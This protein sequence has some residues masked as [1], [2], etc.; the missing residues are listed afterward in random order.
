MTRGYLVYHCLYMVNITYSMRSN[1]L[2]LAWR[3]TK[4]RSAKALIL[5][6]DRYLMKQLAQRIP[7]AHRPLKVDHNLA[8]NP[9]FV[10]IVVNIYGYG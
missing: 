4:H 10:H 9:R 8:R 7:K 2:S 6:I 5:D 3:S 1:D